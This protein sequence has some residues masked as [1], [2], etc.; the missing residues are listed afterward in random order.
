MALSNIESCCELKTWLVLVL[1]LRVM[2][3]VVGKEEEQERT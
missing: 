1:R 2:V 3:S